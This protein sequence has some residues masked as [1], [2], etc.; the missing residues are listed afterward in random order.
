M[1]IEWTIPAGTVIL[2]SVQFVAGLIGMLR[3]FAA[4]ER[5]IEARFNEIKLSLNTFKEGDIRELQGRVAR[6]ETGS[7]EWTKELRER[8]HDATNE[9]SVLKLKVDRLER[10]ERYDRRAGDP[11]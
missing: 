4:I 9:I 10:P 11:S 7:D 6:L 1:Q 3:A 8:T 5:S 2:L